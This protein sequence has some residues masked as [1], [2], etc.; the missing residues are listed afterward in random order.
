[1]KIRDVTA[2]AHWQNPD[3]E[4]LPVTRC[5]CGQTYGPW[6]MVLS[7]YEDRPDTMPCCGRRLF[8]SQTVRILEVLPKD[9]L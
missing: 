6:A 3:D 7:I 9:S 8:W 1:M 4:A 5:P 2:G